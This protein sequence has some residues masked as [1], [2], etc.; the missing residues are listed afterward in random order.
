[1]ARRQDRRSGE[2]EWRDEALIARLETFVARSGWADRRVGLAAIG[3]TDL[4]HSLRRGRDMKHGT[5]ERVL[6][7]LDR[8]EHALDEGAPVPGD[9]LADED[10]RAA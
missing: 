1:M 10:S 8:A 2:R 4:L 5:R 7:W 9:P 3:A 6:A